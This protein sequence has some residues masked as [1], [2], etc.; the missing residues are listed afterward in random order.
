MRD[1][2]KLTTHRLTLGFTGG[3]GKTMLETT[4]R[5]QQAVFV[6]LAWVKTL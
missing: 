6:R 2:E 4:I 3:A 5:N 1:T